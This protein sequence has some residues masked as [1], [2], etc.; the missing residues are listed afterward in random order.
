MSTT[1]LDRQTVDEILTPGR[2]KAVREVATANL[3][4]T[5]LRG[6]PLDQARYIA[7]Y[8]LLLV[9]GLLGQHDGPSVRLKRAVRSIIAT[10]P[11]SGV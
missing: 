4:A 1:A 5:L 9:M 7:E 10:V 6:V 11:T 8:D 3:S 2:A